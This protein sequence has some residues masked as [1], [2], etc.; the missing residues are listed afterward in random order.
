MKAESCA[1]DM[2]TADEDCRYEDMDTKREVAIM[3]FVPF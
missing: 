1:A 2:R 3:I